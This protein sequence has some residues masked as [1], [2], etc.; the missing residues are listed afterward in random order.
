MILDNR[1][2]PKRS[3]LSPQLSLQHALICIIQE[4]LHIIRLLRKL[5]RDNLRN[6]SN[7]GMVVSLQRD[8]FPNATLDSI[9]AGRIRLIGVEGVIHALC[10]EL[11]FELCV[12]DGTVHHECRSGVVFEKVVHPG[13]DS[14]DSG[15]RGIQ[16]ET[17]ETLDEAS[18]KRDGQM[19]RIKKR[20]QQPQEPGTMFRMQQIRIQKRVQFR[21]ELRIIEILL[22]NEVE[23]SREG[24]EGSCAAEIVRVCEEVH[25]EFWAG[26]PGLD[27]VDHHAEEGFALGLGEVVG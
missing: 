17:R 20:I 26:E 5:L 11:G 13:Y 10:I 18:N 12:V 24:E 21:I 25:E 8:D 27:V 1:H 7:I 16:R 4:I 23:Q 3:I 9:R 6:S 14:D 19:R 22:T 2:P 15:W